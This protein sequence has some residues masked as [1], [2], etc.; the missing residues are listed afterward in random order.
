MK[1]LKF[2][3]THVHST[4]SVMDAIG[5]PE[6]YIDYALSREADA[7]CFTEHGNCNS[8]P[9]YFLKTEELNKRGVKFK[10]IPGLEAYFIESLKDWNKLYQADY[11]KRKAGYKGN[12]VIAD[13]LVYEEEGAKKKIEE[14]PIRRRNHLVLLAKHQKG[15]ENL[16]SL[17]SRSY[18]EG[19]YGYPRIDFDFLKQYSDGLV[20]LTGCLAGPFAS[21]IIKADEQGLSFD[22]IQNLLLTLTDQ[23]VDIFDKDHFYYEIQFNKLP[24]QHLVNKH[25][26][27]LSKRTGI[28]L[29]ATNDAHYPEPQLWKE[30]ELYRKLSPK[31]SSIAKK[32]GCLLYLPN[33]VDALECELYPKDG[34]ATFEAY[35]H[36]S[37]DYDFY[38]D[39]TVIQSIENSWH[40]ANDI[41]GDI[42]YDRTIK[43]P[44]S[45]IKDVDEFTQLAQ[46]CIEKLKEKKLNTKQEYVERLKHELKIIKDKNFERYFLTL[47]KGVKHAK[48][49]MLVGPGRGSGSGSLIN[50][51]LNITQIDP[52]R[53]N[54]IF[55]RF[56]NSSRNEY[57]DIDLD[58][59]DK[60]YI[61][62][63]MREVFGDDN[64]ISIS[65]YNKLQLRSLIKDISKFYDVSFQDVNKVT[66][67]MDKE[68]RDRV[69]KRGDDKNLFELTLENATEHSPSFQKFIEEYPHIGTHINILYKNIRSISKHAGGLIIADGLD[70][71]MPIIISKGERQ[72]PWTEG[73]TQ[74][75]L[76]KFGFLKFDCLALLTLRVIRMCIENILVKQDKELTFDNVYDFYYKYLH[77]DSADLKDQKVFENVWWQEKYPNIF[78]FTERGAQKFGTKFKPTSVEDISSI[79]SIFRPGPLASDVHKTILAKR[80][81]KISITFD[82][83][84]IE[85]CLKDTSGEMIYQE[86]IMA[87]AHKLA[88]MS[89]SDCDTLRKVI[90]KRVFTTKD[91]SQ[92]KREELKIQFI[93]GCV[94]NNYP[95]EKAQA[96]FKQIENAAGYL[97]NRSHSIAYSIISYQCAWLFTHYEEEWL[98]AY[99][100]NKDGDDKKAKVISEI[101]SYGYKFKKP[102]INLSSDSWH[103]DGKN[104]Y[105]S[106]NAIKGMGK[107]AIRNIVKYKPYETINDI[108]FNKEKAINKKSLETLTKIGALD[109]VN[110]IGEGKAF[111]HYKHFYDIVI[112]NLAKLR[113]P[114]RGKENL[115]KLLSEY[116]DMGDWS[117][118]EKIQMLSEIMG[119]IDAENFLDESVQ[120]R[121]REYNI[122]S[123]DDFNYETKQDIV[124]FIVKTIS[125]RK[126]KMNKEYVILNTIGENGIEY[127]IKQWNSSGSEFNLFAVYTARLDFDDEWGFSVTHGSKNIMK[128]G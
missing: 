98:R 93:D 113:H 27:T 29:V 22:E 64:V 41:I 117:S 83:P 78:Q 21:R 40:I 111:K 103:I 14:N 72:S 54:L 1:N 57:P 121:L 89:L 88:G 96:L 15:T 37:K 128:I 9:H 16:F 79:T 18:K 126:T 67:V 56:V 77:P 51:L 62:R 74:K 119:T 3:N 10:S 38:D 39:E 99:L 116:I 105:F 84:A 31:F 6:E 75:H 120:A 110:I 92:S 42:T 34:N 102:D 90:L 50:Y 33:S 24:Q 5:Y 109:S 81:G 43:L 12:T 80:A 58:F 26:I 106:L 35:K 76:D 48:K 101:K 95:L 36:Y 28:K 30:R 46:L 49:H 60:E 52:I 100:S 4:Y 59:E 2:I 65:N 114:K 125:V 123:I 32:D 107:A 17:V 115:E 70:S 122:H 11:E 118:K 7:I 25:L 47:Y 108:I 13:T 66:R 68:V 23:F 44:A 104:I 55:E 94:A 82:H 73:V 19:F 91:S 97:F 87:L 45:Q 112:E 71:K 85:E 69:L 63:L 86:Q 8:Y 20:C 61:T 127:N 53:F 124:W